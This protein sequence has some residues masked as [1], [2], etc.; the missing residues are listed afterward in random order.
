MKSN[1]ASTTAHL[2]RLKPAAEERFL[3]QNPW[4]NPQHPAHHQ[5]H[6]AM[7]RQISNLSR[8]ASPVS[9]P[10]GQRRIT[11]LTVPQGSASTIAEPQSGPNSSIAPTPATHEE[12]T[13]T[14]R[15]HQTFPADSSTYAT[16]SRMIETPIATPL[17]DSMASELVN[18]EIKAQQSGMLEHPDAPSSFNNPAQSTSEILHDA[19]KQLPAKEGISLSSS[20]NVTM[21]PRTH[22][23]VI[24]AED[25]TQTSHSSPT[26]NHY[27]NPDISRLGMNGHPE[28]FGVL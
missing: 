28:R 13:R 16:P 15:L 5:Q 14:G 21:S 6:H 3:E 25:P 19:P 8:P 20:S 23:P 17:P 11:D 7:Q 9:T 12:A 26:L 24:K 1:S 22:Y 27:E 4:A 10:I 2:S 18:E